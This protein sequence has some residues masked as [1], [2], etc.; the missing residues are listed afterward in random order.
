VRGSVV[1][2]IFQEGRLPPVQTELRVTIDGGNGNART[3]VVEVAV[4]VDER[5]VRGVALT[6]TGGLARG[7]SVEATGR[8]VAVPVGDAVLGRMFNVFGDVID[9]A[10]AATT[11]MRRSIHS[12][13]PSLVAQG[14]ALEHRGDRSDTQARPTSGSTNRVF[15]TGIKAIDVLVP[16]ER[17]GKAG[18]FGGA[19]VGKT[20]LITELIHNVIKQQKG[21]SVF[22]GIGE[23][24]REGEELYRQIREAGVLDRTVLVYGQMNEPPGARFRVGLAALT[25]A[26]Y[27]R[28]DAHEDV[29]FLVDNIFRF[30][31]AGAEVSGL[32]GRLPSRLGYQ[33]TLATDLAALEERVC[34]TASGAITSVQAVYV[35][36]DD[37]TDPAAVHTFSH[38]CAS[39]VLSRK[40]ASEGL[41]PPV[42]PLQS[43]SKLLTPTVVG[44]RHYRIAQQVRATLAEYEELKDLIAM[45]GIEELS[46]QDRRTVS[47]ARRLERFLTQPFYTT[48]QFTGREGREVA[49]D[50]ALDGCERILGDE[51]AKL[52]ESA[53]YMIGTIKEARNNAGPS[54]AASTGLAATRSQPAAGGTDAAKAAQPA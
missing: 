6:A 8:P 15:H 29:L 43:G 2:A 34:S 40:R 47:R 54:H 7:A 28:D 16:L 36:A 13:P 24:C 18:L 50:D 38:L 37:F 1:D 32:L 27:F 42:D 11:S 52:P 10:G 4:H 41:Y 21:V 33:P 20:V 14:R 39:V 12:V 25:M 23:R 51:F 3:I 30:I 26:E 44:D 22:C 45:L 9:G 5:R 49:L 17:G 48:E 35:P 19:G 53:L 46:E 31:Q